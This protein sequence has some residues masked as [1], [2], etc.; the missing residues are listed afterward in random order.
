VRPLFQIPTALGE[1]RDIAESDT[2]WRTHQLDQGSGPMCPARYV[3]W[4]RGNG[5]QYSRIAEFEAN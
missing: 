3:V 2:R 5:G 4:A 1:A